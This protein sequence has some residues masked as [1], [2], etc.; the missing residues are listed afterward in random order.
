MLIMI[1]ELLK[2]AREEKQ[3]SIAAAEADTKISARYIRA[4]E[5]NDFACLP[6]N[7][8]ALGFI[9]IYGKY[10]GLDSDYLIKEFK[11]INLP[12]ATDTAGGVNKEDLGA[13]DS[14]TLAKINRSPW[15]KWQLGILTAVII[16]VAVCGILYYLGRESPSPIPPPEGDVTQ[17]ISPVPPAVIDEGETPPES[18]TPPE[19]L[20]IEVIAVSGPCWMRAEGSDWVQEYNL[21]TGGSATFADKTLVK[22]RYGN[23][24]AVEVRINGITQEA[25]TETVV[26]REYFAESSAGVFE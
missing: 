16:V 10:L 21:K 13:E 26:T 18:E 23:A 19:G 8:Y 24:R 15:K 20:E 6:G 25:M 11:A 22:V 3:I 1:G 14:D 5:E 4:L 17:P 7:T 12:P 2:Q 9:R